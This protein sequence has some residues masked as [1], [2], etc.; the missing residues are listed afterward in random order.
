[1]QEP[2]SDYKKDRPS[3][4]AVDDTACRALCFTPDADGGVWKDLAPMPGMHVDA[5][6][7]VPAWRGVDELWGLGTPVAEKPLVS[8]EA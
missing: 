5:A 2:R 1:M 4:Y 7:A 6:V 3:N 8:E